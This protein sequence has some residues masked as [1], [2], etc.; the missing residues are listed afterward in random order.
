MTS[1]SG[2]CT[3]Y[4]PW[5]AFIIGIIGSFVA[6]LSVKMFD[7]LKVDDPVSGCSVHGMCGITVR[8]TTVYFLTIIY[9]DEEDASTPCHANEWMKCKKS[10]HPF[11]RAC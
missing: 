2:G 10:N 4:D 6:N 9:F 1:P 8:I 3:L 11:D 5:E 7:H